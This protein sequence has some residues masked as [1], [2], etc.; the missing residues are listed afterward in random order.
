[1]AGIIPRKFAGKDVY[2]VSTSPCEAA[3]IAAFVSCAQRVG[4]SRT[5]EGDH[6]YLARDMVKDLPLCE[7]VRRSARTP[8]KRAITSGDSPALVRG[9]NGFSRTPD[10]RSPPSCRLRQSFNANS[11]DHSR[12]VGRPEKT[13][14][15]STCCLAADHPH[16]SAI[17][18]RRDLARIGCMPRFSARSSEARMVRSATL[19]SSGSA[20]SATWP[21]RHNATAS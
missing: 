18:R 19:R 17:N 9:R 10:P 6:Y 15:S 16:Y 1:M 21:E 7:K 13:A 8:F 5:D 4:K 3:Q 14:P 12:V 2:A 11:A 20:R